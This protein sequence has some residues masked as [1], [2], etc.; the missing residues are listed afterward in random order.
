MGLIEVDANSLHQSGAVF[1]YLKTDQVWS[2]KSPDFNFDEMVNGL[3]LGF[4]LSRWW[5]LFTQ[6]DLNNDGTTDGLDLGLL[7][8]AWGPCP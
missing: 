6:T 4:M 3:D 8:G 2:F 7:L 1:L 5:S